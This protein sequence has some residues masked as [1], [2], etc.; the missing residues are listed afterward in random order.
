MHSRVNCSK[1]PLRERILSREVVVMT[2]QASISTGF[3]PATL[4]LSGVEQE[5]EAVRPICRPQEFRSFNDATA[6]LD[7]F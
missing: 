1:V 7:R 5:W 2:L 6:T 4:V 3:V